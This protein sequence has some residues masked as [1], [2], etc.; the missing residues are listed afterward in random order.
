MVFLEKYVMKVY[1]RSF[2][3]LKNQKFMIYVSKLLYKKNNN[4]K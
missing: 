2:V 4:E 1:I 3:L